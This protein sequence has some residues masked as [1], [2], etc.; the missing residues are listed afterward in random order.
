MHQISSDVLGLSKEAVALARGQKIFYVN[1]AGM[2]LLG[3]VCGQSLG[4]VFGAEV[5]GTQAACFVGTA[6]I[7]GKNHIVRVT[8]QE[9][10]TAIFFG[11]AEESLDLL[12]NALI[13]S[14]RSKMMTCG[15][16]MDIC[17][18]RA[19]E[20]ED[21]ELSDSLAALSQSQY[22][23]NRIVSN[24]TLVQHYLRD[25]MLFEPVELDMAAFVRQYMDTLRTLRSDLEIVCGGAERLYAAIDTNQLGQLLSNLI[26]N[27]LIHGKN[28]SRISVNVIDGGEMAVLSVSDNGCGMESDK[29][30]SVFERYRHVYSMSDM[31][32][33]AGLG[34]TVVR[35][36][37]EKHEGTLLLESRP[38][39]GTT[40][41]VSFRKKLRGNGALHS[42][43]QHYGGEIKSLLLGLAGCLD[44][45]YYM[46]RYM[47]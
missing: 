28:C 32:G 33:G 31:N 23:L 19:D 18:G 4:R 36:V 8:R 39:Q 26:S 6:F 46:E 13:Y 25:E 29:L 45:K 40:V 27:C 24:M 9:D 44:D 15:L 34:L 30:H 21:S 35:G 38:G 17:R 43:E 41:R 5:A 22:G 37:A 11:A 14:L 7:R 16:A 20:L 3:D 47:D 2:G 1:P 42:S 10:V 12:N